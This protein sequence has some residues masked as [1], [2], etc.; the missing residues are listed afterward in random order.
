MYVPTSQELHD[1]EQLHKEFKDY[2]T[3]TKVEITDE[4]IDLLVKDLPADAPLRA[5]SQRLK[6]HNKFNVLS[7]L[8]APYFFSRMI[9]P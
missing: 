5:E 4:T 9:T 7:A 6:R 8:L 2:T 1:Y 3:N